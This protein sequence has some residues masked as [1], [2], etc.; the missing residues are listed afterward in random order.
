MVDLSE[1][2]PQF[3][4]NQ[5]L[6]REQLGFALNRLAGD[7]K[8]SEADRNADRDR[9]LTILESV[10]DQQGPNSETCGLIGRIH[11]DLWDMVRRSDAR[12]ARGHL[13]QAIDA[14]TRGFEA[15]LR[16]AYPG[17][18]AATLLDVQGSDES[19][20]KRDRLVPV[21]RFAVEQR[22][23]TK[24][25]DYWDYATMLELAV[26]GNDR[27]LADENLDSA[28]AI[29][30]ETWMP[31][32]T[33]RNLGLIREFRAARGEDVSWLD[34]LIGALDKKAGK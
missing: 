12:A 21:V 31:E 29:A 9:A 11:K 22:L 28:L 20:A 33:S 14:Y 2:M 1:K 10:E 26:L 5:V 15:D 34:E 19:K 27:D 18:N 4:R 16:D 3:L 25:P 17:I 8:R 24:A 32:T 30:N 6:V 23:R 7:E 13:K